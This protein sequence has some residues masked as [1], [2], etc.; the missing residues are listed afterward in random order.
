VRV[1]A[2]QLEQLVHARA[3]AILVP[4]EQPRDRGDVVG[5]AQVREEPDLLDRVADLAAQLCRTALLH[6][7]PVEEDVA[8]GDVDHAVDHP[9]GGGL[10]AARRA[11][12]HADLPGRD[13]ERE[14]V[15]GRLGLA[16]VAL[17]DLAELERRSRRARR[18]PR[19][20][21]GVWS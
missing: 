19:G 16:G 4:A 2:D 3:D 17:R 20:V 8:V 18:R 14:V 7:A 1:E 11:H 9:H 5:D 6:A 12:E 10:A 13:L 15:D 21:G